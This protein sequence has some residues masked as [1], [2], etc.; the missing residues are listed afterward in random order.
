MPETERRRAFRAASLRTMWLT[1][2][3]LPNRTVASRGDADRTAIGVRDRVLLDVLGC[4]DGL[5]VA[6]SGQNPKIIGRSL[7]ALRMS[8]GYAYDQARSRSASLE[9]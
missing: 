2:Q 1:F 8:R 9:R 3:S 4:G 5:D 6:R 7:S